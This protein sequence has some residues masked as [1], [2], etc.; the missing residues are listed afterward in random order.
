MCVSISGYII[1]RFF[2]LFSCTLLYT[3]YK[4]IYAEQQRIDKHL[5]IN[6]L[7]NMCAA[8][9]RASEIPVTHLLAAIVCYAAR[10]QLPLDS[11]VLIITP[12][13]S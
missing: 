5:I 9:E 6:G 13:L 4:Y 1:L 11:F 3:I 2:C 10:N 12:S 7:Y 8:N